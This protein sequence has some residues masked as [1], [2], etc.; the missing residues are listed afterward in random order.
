M[1]R[2]VKPPLFL[3]KNSIHRRTREVHFTVTK[4]HADHSQADEHKKTA[5]AAAKNPEDAE[6][7]SYETALLDVKAPP[8]KLESSC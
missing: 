4:L 3:T 8:T 7:T 1:D 2:T 6:M 5:T